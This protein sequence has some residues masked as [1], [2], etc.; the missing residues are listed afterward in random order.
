MRKNAIEIPMNKNVIINNTCIDKILFPEAERLWERYETLADRNFLVDFNR[1]DTHV[2]RFSEMFFANKLLADG[3]SLEKYKGSEEGPDLLLEN[4]DRKIWVEVVTP[5]A[6]D[7]LRFRDI[8]VTDICQGSSAHSFKV[9]QNYLRILCALE[10][11]RKQFNK[12]IEKKLIQQ[13]DACVIALNTIALG[14]DGPSGFDVKTVLYDT[15]NAWAYENG[16][17]K[18]VSN[19]SVIKANKTR[20]EMGCFDDRA[21]GSN[22][23]TFISGV[24]FTRAELAWRNTLET[25]IYFAPNSFTDRK[26]PFD[27]FEK[28]I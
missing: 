16:V 28:Y 5:R 21:S 4:G 13:D 25:K 12:Y 9:D 8:D 2:Q 6:G 19:G 15:P 14:L 22:S 11:K 17:I 23:Y 20:I 1:S 3:Y 27:T 18:L 26:I 7:E 10:T 24:L